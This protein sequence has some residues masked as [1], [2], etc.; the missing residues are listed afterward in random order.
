MKLI[1]AIRTVLIFSANTVFGL[2]YSMMYLGETLTL[3]NLTSV[4][5]VIAGLYFLRT[6]ISKDE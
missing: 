1:G 2:I 4:I 3:F 6:R 5:F